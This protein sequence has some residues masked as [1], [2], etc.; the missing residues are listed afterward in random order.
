MRTVTLIAL[1]TFAATGCATIHNPPEMS[2]LPV[3]DS[4]M[5]VGTPACP[6]LNAKG[7]RA[8]RFDRGGHGFQVWPERISTKPTPESGVWLVTGT[9]HNDQMFDHTLRWRKDDHIFFECFIRPGDG[10]YYGPFGFQIERGGVWK[11]YGL[12]ITGVSAAGVGVLG[13]VLVPGAGGPVG[14]AAGGGAAQ[15]LGSALSKLGDRSW[16]KQ[17]GQL[18]QD[19]CEVLARKR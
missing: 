6:K 15:A 5:I 3:P 16:E 19:I 8:C 7:G 1:I 18:A 13:A 14:A 11:T 4:S 12:G 2:Q 9:G 10:S 17:A